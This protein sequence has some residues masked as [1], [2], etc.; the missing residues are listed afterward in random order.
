MTDQQLPADQ[1]QRHRMHQALL[2][3]EQLFNCVFLAAQDGI[4][5]V[6]ADTLDFL[7]VNPAMCSMLGYT[8]SELVTLRMEQLHPSTV[9]ATAREAFASM[10]R[11]ELH[12]CQLSMQ[13]KDGSVFN[14][15]ISASLMEL[16]GKRYLVGLFRDLSTKER[17]EQ[18]EELARQDSLT[19]LSNHRAFQELL[20][21]EVARAQ[22]YGTPVS[23]LMLDIDHFKQIND[24]LGHQAGDSVLRQL[25]HM[26]QDSARTID[27]VCRYGG[28]EFMLILPMTTM[29]EALQVAERLRRQVEQ[30]E[31]SSGAERFSKLTV[32]TGVARYP[33]HAQTPAALIAA[34]DT[35]MYAAK[36]AGRNCSKVPDSAGQD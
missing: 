10:L 13:R 8:R 9:V 28:E 4:I 23:L 29:Q 15:E 6:D 1:E 19:G 21:Q 7:L 20:G 35:A 14:T 18:A 22:R 30:F 3:S 31:F 24:T 34:A 11:G 32:S 26:L 5:V 33:L 2:D 16:Q 27:H 12:Q 17:A 25:A 36:R